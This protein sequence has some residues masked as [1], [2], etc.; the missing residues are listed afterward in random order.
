MAKNNTLINR[1]KILHQKIAEILP[2]T[3][4]AL[5]IALWSTLDM[6]DE[7]KQDAIETIFAESQAIWQECADSHK[8]MIRMCREL[9]GIDVVRTTE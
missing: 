8:N 3:Y 4:A 7:D 9:T 5:A 6:P 2:Q 1:H